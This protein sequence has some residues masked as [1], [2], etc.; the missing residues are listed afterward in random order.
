MKYSCPYCRTTNRL[1]DHDCRF[2]DID[3][4]RIE[5][6]YTD[7]LSVLTRAPQTLPDLRQHVHGEW[8]EIHRTVFQK[9]FVD[10]NRLD[11]LGEVD[12]HNESRSVYKLKTPD[13][14]QAEK[15]VPS[16]P[17]LETIY[18][19]GAVDGCLDTSIVALI[20][21]WEYAGF[22]WKETRELTI[23]WLHESGTWDRGSFEERSPEELVDSKK[24]VFEEGYGWK[25]AAST[26]ATKIPSSGVADD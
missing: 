12:Q 17:D 23:D 15:K 11:K 18:H 2:S 19:E 26:A 9:R 14:I 16:H 24:H 10:E 13:E 8:G 21:W 22:G 4:H 25:D 6:A 3:I 1:H 20:A 7:I 5:K